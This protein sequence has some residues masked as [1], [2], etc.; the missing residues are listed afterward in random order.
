[1]PKDNEIPAEAKAWLLERIIK[2]LYAAKDLEYRFHTLDVKDF[3]NSHGF[4]TLV[5]VDRDCPQIIE[6]YDEGLHGEF[7]AEIIRAPEW[8]IEAGHG[9]EQ[10]ALCYEIWFSYNPRVEIEKLNK[11]IDVL[12]KELV[13][14]K[15]A[16]EILDGGK[17][18]E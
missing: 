6:W 7:D 5:D 16:E 13:P 12:I 8:L 15:M 9:E 10:A 1:M 2:D 3:N 17:K 11:K 14:Y 18:D 4:I